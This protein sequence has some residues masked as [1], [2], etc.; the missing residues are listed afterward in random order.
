MRIYIF[1]I[2][3]S[4][5]VIAFSQQVQWASKLI[6]FSSEYRDKDIPENSTRFRA[7][8]VL[9]YP[10]TMTYGKSVLAWAPGK[11]QAGKE[12]VTVGFSSP[13]T[14]QQ[15]IVGETLNSGAIAEIILFDNAGKKYTVYENPRPA[16]TQK[17]DN[18][19]T[20]FKIKPVY[21]VV[22]LKLI[23][24]TDAII[25]MQQIDCIGISSNQT[26]YVQQINVIKY[27]ETVGLPE[28]LGPNVN[29]AYY[30]HL[31]MISPDGTK[32]Y[33]TRKF[34]EENT[35][36]DRNDDIYYSYIMP[37]GKFSKAE[38]IGP[39]LNND[40]NNF[41]CFISSDNNKLYTANK[42]IRNTYNYNGLSVA[43]KQKDGSWSKPKPINIPNLINNNEFAHYHLNLEETV[44]LMAIQRP[45]SYGDLDL[46]VSLK[47]GDG[48]WSEPK[49]L[50]PVINT[51]GSEGSVFLAADGK[52]LYFSSA[53][54]P[55]FGSYDM[56][57]SKRLDNTW[58]NWSKPLNLGDKINSEE[59][60]IYYTI[61]A[62]GDYAYFSSGR[63][64]FGLNDL[65]RIKLPKEIRPE[66]VDINSYNALAS[67]KKETLP[68]NK[69]DVQLAQLKEQQKATQPIVTPSTPTAPVVTPTT[70]PVKSTQ[71]SSA[72][73]L[74]KQID[75]LKQQQRSV[76]QPSTVKQQPTTTSTVP[77][78]KKEVVNNIQPYEPPPPSPKVLTKEELA[79]REKMKNDPFL[80]PQD[81]ALNRIT[82]NTMP[83]TPRPTE[84]PRE[85]VVA[86]QPKNYTINEVV[87]T[88]NNTPTHT[89]PLKQAQQPA[90]D[91]L[92]QKLD[93]LKKQQS[94][95]KTTSPS[96]TSPSSTYQQQPS[97]AS[98]YPNPTAPIPI[99]NAKTDDLQ[100]KLDA[101]KQQ[102]REVGQ[103]TKIE[104]NPWQP[105]PYDPQPVKEK[106]EDKFAQQYDDYQKKIDELKQQQ[107][108]PTVTSS[109]SP[110]VQQTAKPKEEVPKKVKSSAASKS[111]SAGT[112]TTSPNP[113]ITKYEDKL[114]R[115]QDEMALLNQPKE[116]TPVTIATEN[117]P[118]EQKVVSSPVTPT[119]PL[120]EVNPDFK[121][122]AT[123][124]NA[125]FSQPDVK[126]NSSESTINPEIQK[127]RARLD[128]IEKAGKA[129]YAELADLLDK[130]GNSKQ[131]LEKDISD[132]QQ[133]RK[134]FSDDK[135]KLSAQTSTLESEKTKLELEKKQMDDL[136]VQMHT[137][138]DKIAAE[139]LK[140]EQDKAK[141]DALKKQQEKEVLALK[142]SIDSLSKV[143]QYANA[144]TQLQQDYDLFSIPL[145]VGAVAQV[146]NIYF[147]ADA[148]YLQSLSFPEL[149]KVAAFLSKNSKLKVEIGGHTNGLCD[150][151]FCQKLSSNR[152]KSCVDYLIKKGIAANRLSYK[153]YG[154]TMLLYPQKPDN[155][156]NQRVEIKI[157]SVE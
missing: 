107:K 36:K 2:L 21:N 40:N 56:Y 117:K 43:V 75:A 20:Y 14:V 126:G 121:I 127:E 92:Q 3:T 74:Q 110:T 134:Q 50:G 16:P 89:P 63:T 101:L 140:M 11:S 8:Q 22:K 35:G 57:M 53:G 81:D 106:Q 105:K 10:N 45:D 44:V 142:R 34:A 30:D 91:E 111:E 62:S 100:Q 113:I 147:A 132:L 83:E 47:Y 143:Q 150:D 154:K 151:A 69:S 152:A 49:N 144:N 61:P 39:P 119:D 157:L 109:S 68:V 97:V 32:L 86:P 67:L 25:G 93:E 64:Y 130:L 145:E 98:Q 79:A 108:S 18:V 33:F 70:A 128:S 96:S 99:S 85:T 80:K 6:D 73:D 55:G 60:D 59:M 94:Q 115:L 104:A 155:P 141:L 23:L 12:Y 78:V 66:P 5:Q 103:S 37:N 118:T 135:D 77:A 72:D 95:L 41:I 87:P 131:D 28:N 4:I 129:A 122:D 71:N 84:N 42:Y 146:K 88:D 46:Y 65:Y 153:G 29:S 38:N 149:D 19:L 15:I 82:K 51:V 148:S 137:E 52:T 112:I 54:H 120:A 116:Q 102:Q 31:P 1:F 156:L 125:Q 58:T 139:K 48:T 24:N 90:T 26:P 123:I 17:M 27:S 136:L 7:S 9:G 114:K 133:Q 138:R 124:A 76:N 13:Q